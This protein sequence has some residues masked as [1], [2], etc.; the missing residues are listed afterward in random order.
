[1]AV[2]KN[3]LIFIHERGKYYL[4]KGELVSYEQIRQEAR[5]AGFTKEVENES[6]YRNAFLNTFLEGTGSV[7]FDGTKN[8]I[9]GS[10]AYFQYLEYLE[11]NESLK[12]SKIAQR[13]ANIAVIV[14][15]ITLIVTI[16]TLIHTWKP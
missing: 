4:D 3:I 2:S 6:L 5:E 16:V 11:Y 14:A 10:D 13:T 8:N 15:I 1:M 9:M 7:E 12:S